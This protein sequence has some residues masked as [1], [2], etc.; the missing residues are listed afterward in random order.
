MTN[1]EIRTDSMTIPD[2]EQFLLSCGRIF[3]RITAS[4]PSDSIIHMAVDYDGSD[5]LVNLD[6]VSGELNFSSV[7]NAKSAFVALEKIHKD[8]MERIGKWSATRKIEVA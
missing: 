6:L 7:A 1:V 2:K 4:A 3:E 5:Y 8:S